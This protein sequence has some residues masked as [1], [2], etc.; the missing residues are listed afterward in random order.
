MRAPRA[1]VM[2]AGRTRIQEEN[3]PGKNR[4]DKSEE[5]EDRTIWPLSLPESDL[6]SVIVSSPPATE[7]DLKSPRLTVDFG[8]TS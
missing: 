4:E 5:E 1:I 2:H 8:V 6:L 3:I 7:R